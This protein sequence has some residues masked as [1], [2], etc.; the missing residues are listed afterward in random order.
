MRGQW[1]LDGEGGDELAA[2]PGLLHVSRS[3]VCRLGRRKWAVGNAMQVAA[4]SSRYILAFRASFVSLLLD[5]GG[6]S[7]RMGQ[8][9]VQV[10]SGNREHPC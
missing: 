9:L 7:T 8:W 1:G 10:G 5:G 2:G 4:S 6:E 3:T